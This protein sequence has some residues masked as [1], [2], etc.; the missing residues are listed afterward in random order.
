MARISLAEWVM[1]GLLVALLWRRSPR[2]ASGAGQPAAR[3]WALD[4][5]V[6]V[7]VI[8][9]LAGAIWRLSWLSLLG[10]A[11]AVLGLGLMIRAW[12][13]AVKRWFRAILGRR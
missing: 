7:A 5:C 4:A 3:S 8:G 13:W 6:V 9:I 2:V 11:A 12:S 1:L 10:F